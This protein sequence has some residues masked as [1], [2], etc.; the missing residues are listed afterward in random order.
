MLRRYDLILRTDQDAFIPPGILTERPKHAA[1]FGTVRHSSDFGRARLKGIATK[2]GMRHRGILDICSGW[3]A[4]PGLTLEMAN[5]TGVVG[6][7]VL[8][9]VWSVVLFMSCCMLTHFAHAHTMR[10]SWW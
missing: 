4:P 9:L 8:H 5:L 7:Q 10:I 6:R 1:A 2:L 3:L